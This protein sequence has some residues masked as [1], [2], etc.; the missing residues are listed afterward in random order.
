VKVGPGKTHANYRLRDVAA[1][2]RWLTALL[3]R[4]TVGIEYAR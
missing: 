1:V 2:R 3:L 4:C